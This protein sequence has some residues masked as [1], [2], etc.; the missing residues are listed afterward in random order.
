MK[1]ENFSDI[2]ININIDGENGLTKYTCTECG[3]EFEDQICWKK[4]LSIHG[5]KQFP[6]P[7]PNCGKKFLDNS[8]LR[9]HILVHTVL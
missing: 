7:Y 1:S 8:K 2:N 9:R 3:K 4:H 6:C 5:E